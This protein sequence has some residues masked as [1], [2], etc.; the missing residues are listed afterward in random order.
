MSGEEVYSDEI[1]R[2]LSEYQLL[3]NQ[4]ACS[5]DFER[6]IEILFHSQELIET[7]SFQGVMVDYQF[8]ICTLHNMAFCYSQYFL[9]RIGNLE[10]SVNYLKRSISAYDKFSP[11]HE[12]TVKPKYKSRTFLSLC[13]I[14]ADLK[15]HENALDCARRGVRSILELLD[16][17]IASCSKHNSRHLQFRNSR[18]LQKRIKS[19]RQ[20]KLLES[21]HYLHHHELVAKALPILEYLKSLMKNSRP[22]DL[23]L[24]SLLETGP[25]SAKLTL[26]HIN[27]LA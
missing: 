18:E 26:E 12:D 21:P 15:R 2:C 7:V 17:C 9:F 22:K 6:A 4:F 24:R 16:L 19:H 5:G 23:N 10:E 27:G 25:T 13:K 14:M 3:S 1:P 11:L 8:T 20:Y